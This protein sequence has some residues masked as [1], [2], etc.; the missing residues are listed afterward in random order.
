HPQQ[1]YAWAQ[2]EPKPKKA[3]SGG[4][5]A[6]VAGLMVVAALIGGGAGLGGAWIGF[7]SLDRSNSAQQ[8]S[9]SSST[10]AQNITINNPDDV[11]ET[12]AIAAKA[13]PSVV[14]IQAASDSAGGSGSGVVLSEDGYVLTNTHVVTHGG[15]AAHAQLRVTMSDGTLYNAK[16]VG[17][18]PTYDLAVIKLEGAS[19]LTPMSFADSSK[20]NVGDTSVAIGAPM[21]LNNTV[22]TGVISNLNRAIEIAS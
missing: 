1:T 14:T 3:K 10:G 5:G 22:T 16:I 9:S 21:G 19:G 8:I 4:M 15:E 13:L 12:A 2:P 17:T 7:N 20:L 11:N 18:D 6:K